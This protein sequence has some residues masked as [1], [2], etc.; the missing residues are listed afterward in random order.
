MIAIKLPI[1]GSMVA[2]TIII[3]NSE[4]VVKPIVGIICRMDACLAARSAAAL[5]CNIRELP[6][7]L[8]GKCEKSVLW[9]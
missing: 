1:V 4:H 6:K 3:H 9:S 8:W 2:L 5:A 7:F